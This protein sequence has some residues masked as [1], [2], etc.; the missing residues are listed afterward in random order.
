MKTTFQLRHHQAGVNGV[1]GY[2]IW[3]L[4]IKPRRSVLKIMKVS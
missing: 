4:I 1:I 2:W 3:K